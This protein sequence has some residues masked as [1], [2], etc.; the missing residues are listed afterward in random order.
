MGA[1]TSSPK[2]NLIS[3]KID[4][5]MKAAELKL[6]NMAKLLLLGSGNSGKSTIMKQFKIIHRSGFTHED[7]RIYREV[8]W[9]SAIEGMRA[10]VTTGLEIVGHPSEFYLDATTITTEG[11]TPSLSPADQSIVTKSP[12]VSSLAE[13]IIVGTTI[14]V[15][16]RQQQVPSTDPQKTIHDGGD[17]MNNNS[18]NKI[19]EPANNNNDT[20]IPNEDLNNSNEGI[21]TN[22]N[23][24]DNIPQPRNITSPDTTTDSIS[25]RESELVNNNTN[26]GPPRT[27]AGLQP[28]LDYL[29]NRV[30]DTEPL[31]SS[32][33]VTYSQVVVLRSS[34]STSSKQ[35][36]QQPSSSSS[37]QQQQ[38][39]HQQQQQQQQLLLQPINTNNIEDPSQA[40]LSDEPDSDIDSPTN[41][42]N[43]TNN[44]GSMK[45]NPD[46]FNT[47]DPE[48]LRRMRKKE[49]KR[50]RKR[51]KKEKRRKRREEQRRAEENAPTITLV[52]EIMTVGQL[53]QK[54]WQNPWTQRVYAEIPQMEI[55][56]AYIMQNMDRIASVGYFAT[57]D[58]ILLARKRTSGV[59]LLEFEDERMKKKIQVIDV[60]G[61]KQERRKWLAH[62]QDVNAVIFVVGLDQYDQ[63]MLEDDSQNRLRDSLQLFNEMCT[64]PYFRTVTFFLLLN[65]SDVFRA[66]IREVPLTVCFKTYKNDPHDYEQCIAYIRQRFQKIHAHYVQEWR[67][68]SARR[69]GMG[70]G[71]SQHGVQSQVS[72]PPEKESQMFTFVTNAVDS[73]GTQRII[74]NIKDKLLEIMSNS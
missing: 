59:N 56:I 54:I 44:N 28:Y 32:I 20:T 42:N 65:K 31:Y 73:A 10:L 29:F 50:E 46:S 53:L 1:C 11:G 38:Q 48:E 57:N 12:Q 22:N 21:I 37:S 61:Q 36:Q 66:K 24:M 55:P 70:G 47:E 52:D 35:Q 39:Q 40:M 2:E 13:E 30:K 23:M 17:E 74:D 63:T 27:A 69:A 62:F 72:I 14:N 9:K 4:D 19:L 51:E 7:R 34:S 45:L 64:N 68:S 33:T 43:N 16:Q 26:N 67:E 49:K 58:D 8:L 41:P 6:K 15:Q 3:N 25:P 5:E 71:G 18:N 60:G